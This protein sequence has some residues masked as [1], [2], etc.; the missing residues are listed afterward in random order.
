M[1]LHCY[2]T[3]TELRPGVYERG[4]PYPSL[5]TEWSV[6]EDGLV[7]TFKLREGVEFYPTGAPFNAT[8]VEYSIDRVY[9]HSGSH[10]FVNDTKIVDP[11]TIQLILHDPFPALPVFMSS[12]E[13]IFRI[14]DPSINQTYPDE[15][16][17]LPNEYLHEHTSG[18]G[19]YYVKEWKPR[20]SITWEQ[21]PTWWKGWENYPDAPKRVVMLLNLDDTTLLMMLARGDIDIAHISY[22]MVPEVLAAAE[23]EDLPIKF[24]GQGIAIPSPRMFYLDN[25]RLPTSDQNI[26]KA[27]RAAFDA[28]FYANVEMDGMGV[29]SIGP[30]AP[31]QFGCPDPA[32]WPDLNQSNFYDL[33]K[34]AMYLEAASPDARAALEDTVINSWAGMSESLKASRVL[35]AG[36]DE[37]GVHLDIVELDYASL[38]ELAFT[39]QIRVLYDYY[40]PRADPD[41]QISGFWHTDNWA[42]KRGWNIWEWGNETTDAMIEAARYE[43]DIETRRKMYQDFAK[44]LIRDA[45]TFWVWHPTGAS[46]DNLYWDYVK[47]Y[48]FVQTVH[49]QSWPYLHKE[50]PEGGIP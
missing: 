44:Y 32:D 19:P 38:S 26:R 33:E 48:E 9:Y 40:S 16:P 18:T 30:L 41:T 14:S 45:A 27:F 35:Q 10:R 47:D 8:A 2:D 3:L 5:A 17:Q 43:Q 34:A 20:E 25:S 29:P 15:A 4:E 39:G 37:I 36:L 7:W 28:D 6:S 1:W 49:W 11:Y 23:K 42:T 31:G 22:G 21:N 50:I 24:L 12:H 13:S 46:Y